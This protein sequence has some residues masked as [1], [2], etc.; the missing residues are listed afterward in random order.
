MSVIGLITGVLAAGLGLYLLSIWLIEYDREFQSAAAT[1]LPPPLLAGHVLAAA[2]GLTLWIAFLA[3]DSNRLAWYSVLGF[4]LA[5]V[6]GLTMAYRWI[7]VYRAK[8]ASIRA[9][10]SFLAAPAGSDGFAAAY[11]AD[12]GPPERNFPLTV[13]VAH[14]V[15]AVATL[16]VVL[17]TAVGVFGS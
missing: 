7:S 3:W 15:F 14:G 6:L 12:V 11:A 5:A 10:A 9:A 4:A 13:V 16:T 17:L 8:R 1:R 2:T